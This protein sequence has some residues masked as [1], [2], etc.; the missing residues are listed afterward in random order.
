M[1]GLPEQSEGASCTRLRGSHPPASEASNYKDCPY[2][3]TVP[4]IVIIKTGT[5]HKRHEKEI[6]VVDLEKVILIV[7][8]CFVFN[9]LI[10][11]S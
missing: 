5:L 4:W 2:D 11:M 9:S 10:I 1:R 6:P 7:L 3:H 8:F